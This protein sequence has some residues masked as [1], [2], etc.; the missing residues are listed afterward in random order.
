MRKKISS[1]PGC[2]RIQGLL[3]CDLTTLKE[4]PVDV[5]LLLLVSRK[6]P[7]FI[8]GLCFY[9]DRSEKGKRDYAGAVEGLKK[10]LLRP[11]AFLDYEDSNEPVGKIVLPEDEY[12]E[13]D[14]NSFLAC[15]NVAESFV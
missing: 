15:S 7:D 14:K 2:L 1:A 8:A 10:V 5:D 9:S 4:S 12:I 11:F 13:N 6:Q 3:I